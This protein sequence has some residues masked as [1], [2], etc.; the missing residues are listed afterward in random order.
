MAGGW[1][2]PPQGAPS[3]MGVV[4]HVPTSGG[5]MPRPLLYTVMSGLCGWR[6]KETWGSTPEVPVGGHALLVCFA[7]YVLLS[8]TSAKFNDV[9]CDNATA[10]SDAGNGIPAS[11]LV[12]AVC[13]TVQ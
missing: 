5:H 3:G 6:T 11:C 7:G 10:L 13:V 12:K 8:N 9:W 4:L 2:T 1:G